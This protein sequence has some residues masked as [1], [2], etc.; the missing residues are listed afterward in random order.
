[1]IQSAINTTING[2]PSRF[3][4]NFY[5]EEDIDWVRR[6]FEAWNAFKEVL[7]EKA[8]D[9]D[10]IDH[11]ERSVNIHEAISET[12][13]CILTHCGRYTKSETIKEKIKKR[14][15]DAYDV[16]EEKTVQ[17]KASQMDYDCTSFGPKSIYD[18]L[19]FMDF[20]NGGNI[21]G[22]VDVYDIP[23]EYVNNITVSKKDEISFEARKGEGKRP[24]FSIKKMII[25]EKGL[26]PIYKKVKL[27]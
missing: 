6:C 24:R 8:T 7:N 14:S 2:D 20:Y 5:T 21:D 27:W 4:V 1:M 11:N 12:I 16:V 13:Y 19:I 15:F 3:A 22:T 10:G 9:E 25:E 26:E 17:I 18:K 23:L